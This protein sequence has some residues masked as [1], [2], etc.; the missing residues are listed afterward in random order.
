MTKKKEKPFI[1]REY[2][3]CACCKDMT[4]HKGGQCIACR[5]YSHEAQEQQRR[6][7]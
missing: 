2:F 6:N 4:K 7:K 3:Y 1:D 5:S